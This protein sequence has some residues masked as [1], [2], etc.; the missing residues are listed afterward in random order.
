MNLIVDFLKICNT[1]I[2][3]ETILRYKKYLYESGK[4][5]YIFFVKIWISGSY[6][7]FRPRP[8]IYAEVY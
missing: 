6:H 4:M 2:Q 7:Y 1:N 8:K 5:Y 3:C